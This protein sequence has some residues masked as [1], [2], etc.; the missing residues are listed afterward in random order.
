MKLNPVFYLTLICAFLGSTVVLSGCETESEDND[1][2]GADVG[3]Q[4]SCLP[5]N[6]TVR[7]STNFDSKGGMYPTFTL[8]PEMNKRQRGYVYCEMHW[9]DFNDIRSGSRYF[10]YTQFG[11]MD[12]ERDSIR[13]I[14]SFP[15][16]PS[17]YECR[18]YEDAYYYYHFLCFCDDKC[19]GDDWV[20]V[21]DSEISVGCNAE[22]L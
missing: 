22:I 3:D 20:A 8:T 11:F 19:S 2:Y 1:S 15:W 16:G 14:G 4:P 21:H 17:S 12:G 7:R 13:P 10:K 9:Q 6:Y 5:C 18:N